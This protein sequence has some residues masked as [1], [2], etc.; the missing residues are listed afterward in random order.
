MSSSPTLSRFPFP[1]VLDVLLMRPVEKTVSTYPQ[2]RQ[3]RMRELYRA[4]NQRASV[5][6]DILESHVVAALPLYR[7]AAILYMAAVLTVRSEATLDEPLKNDQVVARFGE[8]DHAKAPPGSEQLL[9]DFMDL[10]VVADPLLL[11]RLSDGDAVDRVQSYRPLI[12]WLRSLTEPRTIREI[13]FQRAIR[14]TFATVVPLALVI[15]G[16]Y[17]LITPVNIAL[18][19]PVV[20][21]SMH[22][23]STSQPSGL[24]DGV[25]SGTYGVHTNQEESPWVQVDLQD[26]Y[27]IDKVSIYNRG[28]GWF[29]DGLPMTLLFSENGTDFKEVDK[30][31]TTFGQWMPWTYK[32]HKARARYIRVAGNKGTFVA[33]SELEVNGKK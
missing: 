20:A 8:L 6:D 17:R 1:T 31:T 22:P 12:A 24:T 3:D 19:K 23:Y 2:S 18:H 16:L 14:V 7:E 28:D 9:R 13:K 15:W 5:A 29:D 26:V 21:S 27:R 30:R 10:L 32:A 25:K 11:D 4:A 33:L